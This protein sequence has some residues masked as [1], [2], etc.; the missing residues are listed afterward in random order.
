MALKKYS[1]L[2]DDLN[3][4]AEKIVDS[5]FHVHKNLGPG[6]PERVYEATLCLELQR[7]NLQFEQ[8]KTISVVYPPD[9]VLDPEYRLDLI[10]EGRIIIELKCVERILPVHQAQLYSYMKM[11]DIQLGFLL[12]FDV[13]LMKDVIRRQCIK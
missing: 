12:N 10:V 9:I 6:Y 1:D 7:R 5:A 2:S 3:E 13:P 4:I 11:S 8:Q